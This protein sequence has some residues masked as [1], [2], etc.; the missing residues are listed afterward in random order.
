MY[1][2][3]SAGTVKVWYLDGSYLEKTETITLNGTSVVAT[4]SI[5]FYRINDF[6]VMSVGSASVAVGDIDIRHLADTPIYSRILAGQTRARDAHFTVPAERE[7]Y[8]RE[9]H[10]SAVHTA[11]NKFALITLRSNYDRLSS[12]SSKIFYPD[13]SLNLSGGFGDLDFDIPLKYPEKIDI[14]MVASSNGT[15][16]ISTAVRGWI[17]DA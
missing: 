7:L 6:Q 12:A 1:N 16:A 17:E 9:V 15:A 11:A 8:I 10:M 13:A 5:D 4:A 2:S 14:I 3:L